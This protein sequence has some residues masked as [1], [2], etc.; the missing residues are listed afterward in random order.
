MTLS[1]N[2]MELEDLLDL[3]LEACKW[4]ISSSHLILQLS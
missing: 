1:K 2:V 3:K 4:H